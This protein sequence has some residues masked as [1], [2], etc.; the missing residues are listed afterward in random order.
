M[1]YRYNRAK[2]LVHETIKPPTFITMEGR[3]R[4]RFPIRAIT[5]RYIIVITDNEERVYTVAEGKDAMGIDY[6]R[7]GKKSL[8]RLQAYAGLLP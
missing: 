8:L 2:D 7:V 5:N 1:R 3:G 6:H 4:K